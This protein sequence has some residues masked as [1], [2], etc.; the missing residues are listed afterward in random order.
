MFCSNCGKEIDDKAVIC[1]HCGCQ[2]NTPTNAIAKKEQNGCLTGCLVM[3]LIF[4][5]IG[6]FF[7]LLAGTV[8]LHSVNEAVNQETGQNSSALYKMIINK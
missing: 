4:G 7:I 6:I 5:V 8:G 2:V 1:I 3:I